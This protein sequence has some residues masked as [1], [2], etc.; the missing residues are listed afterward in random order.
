MYIVKVGDGIKMPMEEE[1]HGDDAREIILTSFLK[2]GYEREVST[3]CDIT[4]ED[5]ELDIEQYF[6]E[7]EID[8]L[9]SIS[10]YT[11]VKEWEFLTVEAIEEKLTLA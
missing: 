11:S 10:D 1:Y 6:S 5:M 2:S 3:V 7:R 8:A 4:W 9:K